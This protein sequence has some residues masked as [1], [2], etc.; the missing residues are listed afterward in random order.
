MVIRPTTPE[1]AEALAAVHRA[2][3]GQDLE[4]DLARALILDDAFVPSLSFAA[5][6]DGVLIG[7]V[8]FTR[9]WLNRDDGLPG[10]PLLLVAHGILGAPGTLQVAVTLDSPEMWRE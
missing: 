7:H 5:E 10:F 4:A 6:E 9:A 1:E 2:A 3:F 8:L